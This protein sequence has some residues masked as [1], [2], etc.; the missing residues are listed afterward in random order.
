MKK[1][2]INH[3]EYDK[4]QNILKHTDL[5]P[6]CVEILIGRGVDT[7]DKVKDFFALDGLSDP[8][9]LK[10]MTEAVDIINNAIEEEK[11]ICVFGDYDCDGITA[12]VIL[13][14]YL[15]CLGANVSYYIPEREEGYGISTNA[16][17]KLSEDGIQLI[18]TVDNGISAVSESELIF[19]LGM[20]L[21]ITDHHQPS[22]T[23]PKASAIVNPHRKDCIS[24][25][26]K[27]CGAGV[28]FK[29]I[30]A[31]DDGSYDAVLEQFSDLTAIGT[32]ADIVKLQGE[33]RPIVLD[34]LHY[35]ANTE[36]LG[37]QAIMRE[38]KIQAASIS[39]TT[40]AFMIA[41]RIN[42][43]G[44]F[45]SPTL[46][47]KLL[48]SE[49]EEEASL[50]AAE[51]SNLNNQRKEVEEKIISEI[52]LIIIENPEILNERA[53]IFSGINWHHGV[54]GIVSAKIVEK[55][56]KPCI[57]ISVE[58]EFSRGSAR[59]IPGFS[60][61]D[62][63][64]DSG[65]ILERF[66]GHTGAG[67]LTIR[68]SRI[69][70]FK[71]S[72]KQYTKENF[73]VMPLRTLTAVKVL[74]TEDLNIKNIENLKV[75]EPFGEGNPRPLFAMIGWKI[76]EIIPL[77]EGRHIKL[78]LKWGNMEISALM[79]G[80]SPQN[81][82]LNKGDIGDFL[83]Y[84]DINEYNGNKSISAKIQDYR[85]NG[86]KQS[87]YFAA[88]ETYE[89]YMLG[90][91]IDSKLFPRIIPSRDDLALIYN[92]IPKND[93]T[94]DELFSILTVNDIN[95]CKLKFAIDAF[96][97]LKLI[98]YNAVSDR[99]TKLNVK[100]KVDLESSKILTTL[101]SELQNGRK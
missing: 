7:T 9:L 6:L 70:E 42:A 38:C 90:E 4:I 79:F 78:K 92:A 72:I 95:Y 28:V 57:I 56:S 43:A 97:E 77:S 75:L 93:I 15:Q 85:L 29:L 55:Y 52:E 59:S 21:I 46:A 84:L 26:K 49:D 18:I 1:W 87:R 60:I 41:P 19:E 88:K 74:T 54:I 36:N 86:L 81:F 69:N 82:K 100:S 89:Q 63:L 68:T 22:E 71:E 34:G 27:L 73:K 83:T 66:G 12:T 5:S 51:L 64:A 48:L 11:S 40:V 94:L 76:S 101:R 53:L 35:L 13:Y 62:A 45:G 44:R 61:F 3:A 10:D 31:L 39:S 2:L 25:F 30:A 91:T 20:D 50:I 65:H 32:I 33:N 99:I 14:S 37:L 23:L 16:I 80:T 96:S 24:P 8:F 17:N 98:K 67:G 58:G 47:V